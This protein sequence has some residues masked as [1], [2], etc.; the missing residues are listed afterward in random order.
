MI[1]HIV[2]WNVH[3]DTPDEKRDAAIMIKT[4]FESLVGQIPGL[5]S[6][7]VGLDISRISY[8]C[9]VVLYSEFDDEAALQRYAEH[10]AHAQLRA[11]LEGVRIARHQV[12]YVC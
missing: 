12:D 3:G 7:E 10:P 6:L 8:A 9:D 2:M 1:K 11:D 4:K 5:R